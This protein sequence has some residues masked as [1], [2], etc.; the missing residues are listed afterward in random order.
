MWFLGLTK[1][2]SIG[3][4]LA[5]ISTSAF[6]F[7]FLRLKSGTGFDCNTFFQHNVI[8]IVRYF[9]I[10]SFNNEHSLYITNTVNY[11][12]KAQSKDAKEYFLSRSEKQLGNHRWKKELCRAEKHNQL[13]Y[14]MVNCLFPQHLAPNDIFNV[15][16]GWEVEECIISCARELLGLVLFIAINV[17]FLWVD[18]SEPISYGK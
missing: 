11:W 15:L 8:S 5:K 4:V 7:C 18:E 13:T 1:D 12:T 10:C 16:L 6:Q 3:S 2:N 17:K 14:C 9:A